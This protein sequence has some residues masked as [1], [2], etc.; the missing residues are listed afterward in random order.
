LHTIAHAETSI[1][2]VTKLRVEMRSEIVIK[3]ACSC[4]L[5]RS[6][7][8]SCELAT[9]K[10]PAFSRNFHL[11]RWSQVPVVRARAIGSAVAA[12]DHRPLKTKK[13]TLK[14]LEFIE[15]RGSHLASE[16]V[17]WE[18]QGGRR[19]GGRPLNPWA[20]GRVSGGMSLGVIWILDYIG[21]PAKPW[22]YRDGRIGSIGGRALDTVRDRPV[23]ST[24][25]L[26][27]P[28]L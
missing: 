2:S 3:N 12:A 10:N 21:K 8:S 26:V 13:T 11:I 16:K 1:R 28:D 25:V 22:D 24:P 17:I 19:K 7:A 15:G 6:L 5:M 27:F 4:E 20:V 9:K 14:I 23:A 18:T